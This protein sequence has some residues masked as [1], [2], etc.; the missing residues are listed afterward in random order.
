MVSLIEIE[1]GEPWESFSLEV[2]RS[3]QQFYYLAD[4]IREATCNYIESTI[5]KTVFKQRLIPH[6]D[7][8][9][10]HSKIKMRKSNG[11]YFASMLKTV[12]SYNS[13]G[14]GAEKDF[15]FVNWPWLNFISLENFVDALKEALTLWHS[16]LRIAVDLGEK[17][18]EE[19]L[20][21]AFCNA[22]FV[23]KSKIE[24]L[25]LKPLL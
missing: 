24:E 9:K 4:L 7:Y 14:E 21:T 2:D 3:I 12:L 8:M 13:S 5:F 25:N 6:K 10:I 23:L 11:K 16:V 18:G 22:D 15:S 20:K 19:Y 17:S 1:F